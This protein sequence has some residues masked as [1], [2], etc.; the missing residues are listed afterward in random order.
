MINPYN[1]IGG[2]YYNQSDYPLAFDYYFK[3]LKIS[4]ELGNKRGMAMSYTNIGIL[5]T[6]IYEQGDASTDLS[7]EAKAK[8]DSV[9]KGVGGRVT[10]RSTLLDSALYYQK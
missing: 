2:I 5:Y 6:A 4:E 10:D 7:P 9:A 8:E 1:N 3:A